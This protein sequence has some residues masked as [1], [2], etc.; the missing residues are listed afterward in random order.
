MGVHRNM[1]YDK[2]PKQGD[3]LNKRCRVCFNYN[4]SKI[5]KGIIVRDD[6]EEPLI[7]IIRLDDGRYVLATECQYSLEG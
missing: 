7:T 6:I 4:T 1:D 2:F 3:F 5:V